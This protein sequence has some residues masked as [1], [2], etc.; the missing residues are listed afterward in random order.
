MLIFLEGV[1][2]K[3]YLPSFS[4]IL[5]IA[6]DPVV[7][8]IYL[9]AIIKGNFPLRPAV[10][11][12]GLMAFFSAIFSLMT[13][14]PPVVAVFGLRTNYLHPP[15]VFIMGTL[16]DR[17]DA[18][19]YCKWLLYLSI[20]ILL[21]MLVQFRSPPGAFIN[22]GVGASTEGQ[23]LGAM[24]R[25]RP[26]GPFSFTTGI[27]YFFGLITAIVCHGWI[28]PGVYP[29]WLLITATVIV[30]AAVPVSISRATLMLSLIH[31]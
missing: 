10:F 20:P 13:D 1:L 27:V 3:W 14:T 24:G 19:R 18:E 23:L 2:R 15:L 7:L 26:S 4:N 22:A 16:L 6:R 9:L 28:R 5:F 21:I 31:I 17:K 29:R 11:A 8:L 30:V 25:V 12:L